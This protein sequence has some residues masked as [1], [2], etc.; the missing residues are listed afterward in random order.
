MN[1]RSLVVAATISVAALAGCAG[2][3]FDFDAARKVQVGMTR[4]EVEQ[5][6]GK[7]Y[8]VTTRGDAET[9]IWSHASAFSGAQSVSFVFK[10]GKVVQVPNIPASFR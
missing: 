6:M 3:S 9:W 5:L 4:A 1:A 10:D 2:T 8:M 7:P